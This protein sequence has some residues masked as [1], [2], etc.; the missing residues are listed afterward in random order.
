MLSSSSRKAAVPKEET[1]PLLGA[2]TDVRASVCDSIEVCVCL[3]I[4]CE[5]YVWF[6]CCG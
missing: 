1:K 4:L 3:I 2:M 6:V 5:G